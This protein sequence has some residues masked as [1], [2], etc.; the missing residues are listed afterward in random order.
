MF[1]QAPLQQVSVFDARG[2][3]LFRAHPAAT[4]R[5]LEIDLSGVAPGILLVQ[6]VQADGRLNYLRV[7]KTAR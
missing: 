4:L 2:R 6:V 7:V 5:E 1:W 3:L